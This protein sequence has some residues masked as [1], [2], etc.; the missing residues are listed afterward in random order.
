MSRWPMIWVLAVLSVTGCRR[1]MSSPDAGDDLDGGVTSADAGDY[2]PVTGNR[3]VGPVS[4]D[5]DRVRGVDGSG[6]RAGSLP[7]REPVLGRIYRIADG[8]TV[9]FT[10][11]DGSLDAKVRLIGID[12]PEIS[13]M[14]A[15]ADCYGDEASVFTQQLLDRTV[16]LTFDAGCRDNFDRL[17]AYVH[18]GPGSGDMWQRQLL[19]RGF[20]TTLTVAPNSQFAGLF[21]EDAAAARRRN[22]GLWGA[23]P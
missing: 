10:A 11:A 12:T 13:H 20:A 1:M 23:C 2:D 15:P 3:F 6:L 16:W 8:D 19:Q 21:A 14:G 9:S 5:D 17:L 22:A 4:F 18:V 7:C